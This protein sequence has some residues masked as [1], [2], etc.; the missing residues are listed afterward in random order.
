ML[1]K[2][3]AESQYRFW[4][5]TCIEAFLRGS[6]LP[7]HQAFVAQ[8]GLLQMLVHE[9]APLHAAQSAQHVQPPQPSFD[10]LGEGAEYFRAG[11]NIIARSTAATILP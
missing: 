11:L 5:S 3:P 4:L 9:I 7:P 1:L 8:S 10:L 6:S 2:E